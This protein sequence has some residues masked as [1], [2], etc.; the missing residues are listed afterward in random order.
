MPERF[1]QLSATNDV[2]KLAATDQFFVYTPTVVGVT[3]KFIYAGTIVGGK[4]NITFTTDPDKTIPRLRVVQEEVNKLYAA[5]HAKVLALA[6]QQP[7]V[8]VGTG[9]DNSSG[10]KGQMKQVGKALSSLL[11]KKR[12]VGDFEIK[13]ST[14]SEKVFERLITKFMKIIINGAPIEFPATKLVPEPVAAPAKP[15]AKG[16]PRLRPTGARP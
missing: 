14:P 15:A 3:D 5:D 11:G 2:P 4:L 12:T 8:Q 10:I 1:L 9:A 16:K 13:D 6:P 7:A